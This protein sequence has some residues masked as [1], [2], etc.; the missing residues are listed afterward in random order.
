MI[1]REVDHPCL[2][3]IDNHDC[4][5][6]SDPRAGQLFFES[7]V[8]FKDTFTKQLPRHVRNKVQS[9]TVKVDFNDIPTPVN[10]S[11]V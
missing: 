9:I 6:Q 3:N 5:G 2:V 7:V 11:E 8:T 1:S 4:E 10:S